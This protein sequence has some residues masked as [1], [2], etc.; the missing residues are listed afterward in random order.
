MDSHVQHPIPLRASHM[1]QIHSGDVGHTRPCCDPHMRS[2]ASI[3]KIH[4]HRDVF[5]AWNSGFC[6]SELDF[7][8]SRG[9]FVLTLNI[10]DSTG[11]T[12]V[13]CPRGPWG[14]IQALYLDGDDICMLFHIS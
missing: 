2:H 7:G 11:R 9:F 8:P 4:V 13:G 12:H 6:G 5:M 14:L 1:G 10:I 3:L